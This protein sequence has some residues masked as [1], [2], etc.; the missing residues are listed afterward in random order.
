MR[1]GKELVGSSI[2]WGIRANSFLPQ[3]F[4]NA[5]LHTGVPSS[6]NLTRVRFMNQNT[7]SYV[8]NRNLS[9]FPPVMDESRPMMK[10]FTGAP[11]ST[12]DGVIPMLINM[13]INGVRYDIL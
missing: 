7:F 10:D 11:L 3:Q 4:N 8:L 6:I 5:A 12:T 13:S 9:A 1:R 2:I